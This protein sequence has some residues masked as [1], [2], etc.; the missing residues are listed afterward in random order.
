MKNPKTSNDE[1]HV[2]ANVG[3]VGTREGIELK[4]SQGFKLDELDVW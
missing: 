4:W 2:Q 3:G 1:T